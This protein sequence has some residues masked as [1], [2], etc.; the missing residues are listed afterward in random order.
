MKTSEKL[1]AKMNVASC[2]EEFIE[3]EKVAI[4]YLEACLEDEKREHD[5]EVDDST[6]ES[7]RIHNKAIEIATQIL[8]KLDS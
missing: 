8:Y 1:C 4:E 3:D 6:K 7:I 2:L 5:A